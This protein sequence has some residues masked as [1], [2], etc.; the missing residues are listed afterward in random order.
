MFCIFCLLS[1]LIT[2]NSYSNPLGNGYT[3]IDSSVTLYMAK[4][5]KQG[6]IIY[7]DMFDHKGPLLFFINYLAY[8]INPKWGIWMIENIIIM[9]IK[10]I[11]KI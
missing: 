7:L 11:G 2:A 3:S 1:L 10:S 4:L 5:M 8:L 9:A 6:K